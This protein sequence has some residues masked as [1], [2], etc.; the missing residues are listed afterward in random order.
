MWLPQ[1]AKISYT[2]IVWVTYSK[3]TNTFYM[4]R[5]RGGSDT[6]ESPGALPPLSIGMK[7]DGKLPFM[8]C[9]PGHCARSSW[10]SAS[11]CTV[12][13]RGQETQW[14]CFF[15]LFFSPL[16][17][18]VF[19]T[20]SLLSISKQQKPQIFFIIADTVTVR[21]WQRFLSLTRIKNSFFKEDVLEEKPVRPTKCQVFSLWARETDKAQWCTGSFLPKLDNCLQT[22]WTCHRIKEICWIHLLWKL[23]SRHYVWVSCVSTV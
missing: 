21:C 20:W 1:L 22:V 18:H 12:C 6:V 23:V 10:S 13:E 5:K 2:L 15:F 17:R 8:R 19:L 4:T 9:Y 3:E 11:Y 16:Q 14:A 7:W